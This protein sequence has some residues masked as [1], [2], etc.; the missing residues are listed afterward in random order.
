MK[1][2]KIH[3]QHTDKGYLKDTRGAIAVIFALTLT[4]F[5]LVT[6]M[7]LETARIAY[8]ETGLAYA[9]DAAAIA[10]ARYRLADINTNAKKLFNANFSQQN[11]QSSIAPNITI[12]PDNTTVTVSASSTIPAYLG[13]IAGISQLKVNST[14]TVQR[15]FLNSEIALVLDNTGSMAANSK[16]QGLRD[17]AT[18]LI[19]VVFQNQDTSSTVAVSIV[20]YVAA[21]NIGT[22]NKSWLAADPAKLNFPSDAP[23]AGCVGAID[24]GTTMNKDDPP[25]S[26]RKWPVYRAA[27]TYGL[28]GTQKGNNDW[29]IVNGKLNVV[30]P[31]FDGGTGTYVKVGPNRSCGLP[32]QPLTNKR[33]TL[34]ST[35]SNMQPV[36]GGGTFG[37]IGL[38]WG[39]NTISPKWAGL[40]GS[41]SVSPKPYNT[42]GLQKYVVIVTDGENQWHAA[43]GLV[44]QGD[45]TAYGYSQPSPSYVAQGL[46]GTTSLSQATNKINQRLQDLCSRIKNTGIQIFTITFRVSD[47]TAKQIYQQCATKSSYAFQAEDSQQLYD[48]FENIANITQR[49]RI[50]K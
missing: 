43:S 38:I 41:G 48:I 18:N 4:P 11:M 8:V 7:A 16:I 15:T 6:G 26:S 14:S 12:S 34:L 42:Q 9:C 25:S 40:W 21:V 33:Q 30:N 20:P 24:T 37:D 10:G 1:K 44:P 47:S 46:L 49:I 2:P 27:S 19:N 28:F 17:A 50:V 22:S 35:V 23:W 3:R 36:P 39:W 45:P 29:N 32:I 5:I 13:T 31:I